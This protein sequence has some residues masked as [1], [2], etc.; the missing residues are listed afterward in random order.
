MRFL[1]IYILTIF[2]CQSLIELPA[3]Y[4]NDFPSNYFIIHVYPWNNFI[5]L[6]IA[7]AL[8]P[9]C[10]EYKY[11]Y[12]RKKEFFS[13]VRSRIIGTIYSKYNCISCYI[14]SH[15]IKYKVKWVYIKFFFHLPRSISPPTTNKH[16]G[17]F[18]SAKRVSK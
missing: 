1:Y 8:L 2:H 17:N 11:K 10:F 5:L 12:D 15:K 7:I 9:F 13:T 4:V 6:T 18:E 14:L 16:R 3:F